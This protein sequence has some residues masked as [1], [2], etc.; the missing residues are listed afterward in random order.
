[1][2]FESRARSDAPKLA[3]DDLGTLHLVPRESPGGPFA[4]SHVLYTRLTSAAV[5]FENP[6]VISGPPS[7]QGASFPSLGLGARNQ[8]YIAWQHHPDPRG[9]ARGLGFAFSR[10]GGQTFTAPAVVPGSADRALGING[11]RQGKLM[12]FLDANRAGT[13][14]V[15]VSRFREHERSDVSLILG[16]LTSL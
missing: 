4:P 13:L 7:D 5:A 6:R 8:V 10:D 12:R 9:A 1:M 2:A 14:A 11:S 16:K 15:V 3:V